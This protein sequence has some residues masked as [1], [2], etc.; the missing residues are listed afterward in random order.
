MIRHLIRRYTTSP[1]SNV[2]KGTKFEHLTIETLKTKLNIKSVRTG[3]CNDKGV[4]FLGYL[5]LTPKLNL[6]IVGQCKHEKRLLG[7]HRVREFEGSLLQYK[8]RIHHKN[9]LYLGILVSNLG[10]S[11]KA[12]EQFQS[13]SL[14][15]MLCIID[16]E[17]GELTECCFNNETIKNINQLLIKRNQISKNDWAVYYKENKVN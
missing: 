3:Q 9:L 16:S 13:S 17:R 10:F 7:P 12:I 5:K 11:K 1:M 2:E 8:N 6:D 4:D 14:N 15:L